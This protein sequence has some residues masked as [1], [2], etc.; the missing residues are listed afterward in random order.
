MSQIMNM[1]N[2]EQYVGIVLDKFGKLP[3][4]HVSKNEVILSFGNYS[5]EDWRQL[6]TKINITLMALK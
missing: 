5:P 6:F 2:G 4:A 1:K 3:V